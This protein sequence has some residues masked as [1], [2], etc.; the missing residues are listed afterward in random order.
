MSTPENQI[1]A[2]QIGRFIE[3]LC[4]VLACIGGA[5]FVIEAV[6]SVISVIGRTFFSMPVPGDYE[7]IQVL[8]AVGITLCLP[9]CQLRQGH[10]FVDFFT[11]WAPDW[12]KNYLD[13]LACVLLALFAFFLAWRSWDGMMDMREYEE[14]S[15]VLGLPLWWGYV[16]ITPSFIVFGITALYTIKYC[17]QPRPSI[18]PKEAAQ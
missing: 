11:L 2:G 10:V 14:T 8:T 6:M 3:C 5:L 13:A 18:D 17:W 16:P 12:L 15:M 1:A 7:L 9:Y 4:I